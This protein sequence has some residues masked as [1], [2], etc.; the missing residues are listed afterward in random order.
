[1]RVQLALSLKS[2]FHFNRMVSS[3]C[4]RQARDFSWN[5]W[6]T[7]CNGKTA[8]IPTRA[9]NTLFQIL[10]RFVNYTLVTT[11]MVQAH[12]VT[13]FS[14]MALEANLSI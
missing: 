11:M 7:Y 5:T 2:V 6:D 9:W 3:R 14:P 1:M 12:L 4:V 13:L 10:G 8:T